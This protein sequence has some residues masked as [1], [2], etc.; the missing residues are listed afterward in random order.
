MSTSVTKKTL[1]FMRMRHMLSIVDFNRHKL[2]DEAGSI[3]NVGLLRETF[4][5]SFDHLMA[6]KGA[7]SGT[8]AVVLALGPSL[9]TIDKAK[10]AD[11]LKITCNYFYKV[12]IF[13]DM[14]KPDIWTGANSLEVLEE[15][16]IKCLKD[17]I[18][19]FMTIPK[20]TEFIHLMKKIPTKK[21][22]LMLAWDWNMQ[23]FQHMLSIQNGLSTVYSHGNTVTTHMIALALWL[24]CDRI[25]IAGF[26][27]SYSEALRR[28]GMTH[29]GYSHDT[30]EE[31][32]QTI[33]LRNGQN[34]FDHPHSRLQI[35]NDLKYLC[36]IASLNSIQIIN[37]ASEINRLPRQLS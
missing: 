7:Y 27:M 6:M 10:Y 4:I 9:L 26:D 8:S 20:K 3:N 36:Y 29:A 12:P 18:Y 19:C 15:P 25:E 28:T 5:N 31:D 34:M 1:D 24:G 22:H 2:P 37:L 30:S 23:I 13:D 35:I 11:S 17:D 21:D 33:A 14:F 16:A 32:A